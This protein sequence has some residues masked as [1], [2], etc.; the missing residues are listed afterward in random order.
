MMALDAYVTGAVSIAVWIGIAILL[1]GL[2]LGAY[3]F[4]KKW[5]L[6]SEYDC[7]IFYR[8]GFGQMSC[9]KDKAGI[10]TDNKTNNKR[11]FMK[12]A[13]VGLEP[14]NIPVIPT[15]GRSIVYLV[16]YGLKNLSFVRVKMD[17]DLESLKFSVGEEDVNWAINAYEREKKKWDIKDTLMQYM[18][19]IAFTLT[20]VIIMII[21]IYWFKAIPGMLEGVRQ[22]VIESQKLAAMNQGT[23]IIPG[24]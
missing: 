7:I 12:K 23:T 19:Y 6:Y 13:N 2:G 17:K 9:K 15:K 18:P 5:Y 8:D 14:D 3:F 10:F 20:I 24:G 22:A 21:M 4:L 11:F 1:A 16:Q